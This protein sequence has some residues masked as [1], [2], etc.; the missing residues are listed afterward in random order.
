[1]QQEVQVLTS[2]GPNLSLTVPDPLGMSDREDVHLQAPAI[3]PSENTHPFE[4][5]SRVSHEPGFEKLSENDV[6]HFL[7]TFERIP[8]ACRWPK[9][10]WVFCIIL[11]MTGKA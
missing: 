10:D 3:T 1:M 7:I 4:I 8:A 11:L 5:Y 9:S 2:P 6:E